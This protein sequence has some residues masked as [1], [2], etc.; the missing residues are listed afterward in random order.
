[1]QGTRSSQRDMR[2]GVFEID[3]QARELRKKGSKVRLQRQPFELLLV[4]LDRPGEVVSREELRQRLWPTD[5]YVDFARSL[6][7]AMVKLRE[8]LGDSSDS[9]LYVETL[10]RVGYRFIGMLNG[11]AQ[12]PPAAA[13]SLQLP[14]YSSAPDS[15]ASPAESSAGA[16]TIPA[17]PPSHTWRKHSRLLVLTAA[18]LLL[19]PPPPAVRAVRRPPPRQ[20]CRRPRARLLRRRHDR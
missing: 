10:P 8:A 9:P 16:A 2:F 11:A 3:V 1:M 6:T 20:S 15:P 17:A 5:V 4:L 19:I 13:G 7:K 18:A 14:A 12:A